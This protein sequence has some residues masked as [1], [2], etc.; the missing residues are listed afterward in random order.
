[1]NK[2]E[3]FGAG[4]FAFVGAV[5]LVIGILVHSNNTKFMETAKSIEAEITD[6]RVGYDSDGDTT[7]DV[8]V[9]FVIDGERY[10]GKLD[11]YTSSM[12][13]GGTTTVYYD[14]QNPHDFRGS[15]TGFIGIVFSGMGGL[16]FVIGIV[17]IVNKVKSS[18]NAKTLK[19]TGTLLHAKINDVTLNTAYAVNGRNPYRL[20]ASAEDP[21]TGKT[22]VFES[23][24]VWFNVKAIVD[25][26]TVETVDVY[27]D[28]TNPKKYFVDVESLRSYIGN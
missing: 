3:L 8:L 20:T 26:N 1:M 6:I 4:L 18:A 19:A 21:S 10:G 22:L 16:F 25:N 15:G 5:F 13:E 23:G 14:P 11:T 9:E 12:R 24:N 28:P 17:M 2:T 7:H 27:L